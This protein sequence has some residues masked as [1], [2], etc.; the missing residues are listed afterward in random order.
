MISNLE[1][2]GRDEICSSNEINI[3]CSYYQVLKLVRN[4]L[5][6]FRN[7][8]NR[9]ANRHE[10]IWRWRIPAS[11]EILYLKVAGTHTHRQDS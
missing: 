6:S 7:R 2:S 5:A 9:D 11:P 1:W 3:S 4:N 10:G 8:V